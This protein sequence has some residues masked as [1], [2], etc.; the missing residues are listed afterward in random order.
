MAKKHKKS[1]FKKH[2]VLRLVG[3]PLM[4]AGH[5]AATA[6]GGP[7]ATAATAAGATMVVVWCGCDINDFAKQRKKEQRKNRNKHNKRK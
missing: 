3:E 4:V 7:A 5:V 1:R 2:D 6:A